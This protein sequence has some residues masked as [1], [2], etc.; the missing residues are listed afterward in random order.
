M[1]DVTAKAVISVYAQTN[2]AVREIEKARA[3]VE[4][5]GD[6]S[7][8]S[9]GTLTSF[10]E[11]AASGFGKFNLA[12]GGVEKAFGLL[13]GALDTALNGQRLANLEKMLPTGAVER[14]REA[15]D[16]MI[17]RQDVLR[18]SVKGLSGDFKL[19]EDQMQTVLK[20]SLAL[21]QRTGEA[22]DVIADKLI[23]ALAKGVNKL[24]DYGINLDK[25]KSRTDDV[26]AAMEK[27][28]D[29]ISETPIDERTKSLTQLKDS[30]LEI[31]GAIAGIVAEAAKAV[32]WI[33][34]NWRE[35][36]PDLFGGTADNERKA[37]AERAKAEWEEQ[38]RQR[39]IGY[40]GGYTLDTENLSRER[41]V[42]GM[43]ISQWREKV[44]KDYDAKY[45]AVDDSKAFKAQKFGTG[46]VPVYVTNAREVGEHVVVPFSATGEGDFG[47][48][49]WDSN[50]LDRLEH[51]P[52]GWSTSANQIATATRRTGLASLQGQGQ[53]IYGGSGESSSLF[54]TYS[55]GYDASNPLG[56][57]S[58]KA[59][60]E[61]PFAGGAF[62]IGA[63]AMMA[64]IDAAITGQESIGKAMAKASAMALK[65]K[66]I[67]W[68]AF[69]IGE[70]AWALAD[71]AIGNAAGAA[72]HGASAL[73]FGLAAAA[74][75]VGASALGS[76]AGGGGGGAAS[77]AGGG[78]AS[79]TAGRPDAKSG[80]DTIIVNLGDGFYGDASE[81]A[82][83][84]ARGVRDGKRRSGTRETYATSFSG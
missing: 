69:A 66:A 41:Q 44:M 14:F 63:G 40:G 61:S 83:A 15:T 34:D 60:G 70:G 30:L 59:H 84:V 81:V 11:G 20:T 31:G 77:S 55:G 21:S 19:T 28:K 75:G 36:A 47:G 24:D 39:L 12:V 4:G 17:S 6:S 58:D 43:P 27:F 72:A 3:S 54:G 1:A 7:K 29:I 82:E 64:G 53:S 56:S 62:D 32:A 52:F 74:A 18:L 25:T 50:A 48:A 57:F 9:S 80:A 26:N 33:G 5:L 68:G 13:N 37:I 42:D 51:N 46:G 49:A 67:E 73:Q 79:P 76:L 23:D 2:D 71:L 16:K 65:S 38:H 78:Y 45:G 8:K 10:I 35:Y 22:A